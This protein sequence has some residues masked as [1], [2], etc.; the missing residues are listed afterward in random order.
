VPRTSAMNSRAAAPRSFFNTALEL[1]D[2]S[3]KLIRIPYPRKHPTRLSLP[4]K[5]DFGEDAF[6][7]DQ[8]LGITS[9]PPRLEV[10]AAD[11]E[12]FRR[13]GRGPR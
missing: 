6:N 12:W 7:A 1:P 3:R 9:P 2:P 8:E 10:S 5:T 13:L 11:E 4:P